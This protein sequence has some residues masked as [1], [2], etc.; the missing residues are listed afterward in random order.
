M[1]FSVTFPAQPSS[2]LASELTDVL[3]CPQAQAG[4]GATFG[5]VAS[6]Q[7]QVR[8]GLPCPVE[9]AVAPSDL[10][11]S[12]CCWNESSN[13][14]AICRITLVVGSGWPFR[15]GGLNMVGDPTRMLVMVG[16]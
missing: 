5:F 6:P 12:V 7:V 4:A 16:G 15:C 1:A 10:F 9:L 13:I 2:S 14:W 3:S 11:F 8:L